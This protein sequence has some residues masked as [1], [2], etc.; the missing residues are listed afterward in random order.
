MKTAAS[1]PIRPK[2]DLKRKLEPTQETSQLFETR[3]EE[4]EKGNW[5]EVKKLNE[6]IKTNVRK[7]KNMYE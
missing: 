4:K 1:N 5:E 3:Q 2:S 7:D 6:E